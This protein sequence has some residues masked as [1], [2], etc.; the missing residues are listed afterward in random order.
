MTRP[1]RAETTVERDVWLAL[2][3]FLAKAL[4]LKERNVGGWEIVS[5]ARDITLAAYGYQGEFTHRP[6][7]VGSKDNLVIQLNIR[8]GS[9]PIAE[10]EMYA[11]KNQIAQALVLF[12]H[13]SIAG[14]VPKSWSF[15][16]GKDKGEFTN[17]V[18]V[19]GEITF[20]TRPTPLFNDLEPLQIYELIFKNPVQEPL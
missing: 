18:Q 1:D 9:A 12:T 17:V 11:I 20:I 2:R 7:M 8:S 10:N 14:V 5:D 3:A 13:R 6:Q 4:G 19:E 15:D 16:T